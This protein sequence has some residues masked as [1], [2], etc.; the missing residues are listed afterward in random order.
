ME[1]PPVHPDSYD[2]LMLRL[3]EQE[4][5][6]VKVCMEHMQ[7]TPEFTMANMFGWGIAGRASAMT[8]GFRSMIEQKNS[9]C[10]LPLLRMQ[11]D[12]V[13]RLYA[14]F[15][16]TDHIDF[17]TKIFRG[18]RIDRMKSFDGHRMT[19]KFLVKRVAVQ[20]PWMTRVY[21]TTSGYIHLSGKPIQHVIR[22]ESDGTRHIII[23]PQDK[24]RQP[25][26]FLD[27]ILCMRHLNDIL[28]HTLSDWF[29]RMCSPDGKVIPHPDHDTA[30]KR[31]QGVAG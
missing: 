1:Q 31:R 9:L 14:G 22:E 17:C 3:S 25:E 13:L 5:S 8:S 21:E 28:E 10:A 26:Q 27:P 24:D 30:Q 20:N 16:A 15:F 12:N 19:D 4:G 2:A 7:R 29:S 6:I 18:D 23:G 11:L